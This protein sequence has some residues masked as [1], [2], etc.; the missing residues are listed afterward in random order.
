MK[1]KKKNFNYWTKPADSSIGDQSWVAFVASSVEEK[2]L[3][4]VSVGEG[5]MKVE[6]GYKWKK[7]KKN[8]EREKKKK[9]TE[10]KS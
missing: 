1:K 9:Q 2:C 4:Q 6:K 8:R 10:R 7:W 3:T 5:G